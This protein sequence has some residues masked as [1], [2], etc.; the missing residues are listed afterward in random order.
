MNKIIIIFDCA[1]SLA[2]AVSTR[3]VIVA[4]S[5][6]G[7]W[8]WPNSQPVGGSSSTLPTNEKITAITGL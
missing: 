4:N 5:I 6:K 7:V 1:G 2:N 8:F 3:S